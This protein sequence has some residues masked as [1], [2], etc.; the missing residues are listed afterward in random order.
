[1]LFFWN[2]ASHHIWRHW[3]IWTSTTTNCQ[4]RLVQHCTR[5]P[6]K[7]TS[8]ELESSQN[9]NLA[10]FAGSVPDSFFGLSKL[11]TIDLSGNQ[12]NGVY[13]CNNWPNNLNSASLKVITCRY[14]SLSGKFPQAI[15][16]STNL[17][18]I[19]LERNSLSGKIRTT[20]YH[21]PIQ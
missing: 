11:S 21:N 2:C 14:K 5:T 1:M 12:L 16:F 18:I 6:Y 17:K 8:N 7:I 9:T 4:V 20:L 13:D 3:H 19:S 15:G 10:T